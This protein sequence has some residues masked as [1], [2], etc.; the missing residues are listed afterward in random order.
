MVAAM[1]T[2]ST[3]NLIFAVWGAGDLRG[4]TL[5]EA[6]AEVGVETL[7]VNVQD[8]AVEGALALQHVETPIESVLVTSG[9]DPSGVLAI[10]NAYA[11]HVVGWEV[12]ARVVLPPPRV[13]NGNRAPV[14]AQ[15][16]FLRCPDSMPYDEWLAYW[17]G[18][19]TPVAVETQGTVGYVQNR[20]I[21]ALT[22]DTPQVDAIVEELFPMAALTDMHAYYGSSGDDDEL[23]RRIARLM[24]SV[25]HMGA[26]RDLD[27]VPTS[28]YVWEL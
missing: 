16:A 1:T 26:D 14:M 12:D 13:G 17:Q 2:L 3:T 5:R 21:K 18:P 4:Q 27:L 8:A 7:Q 24:E 19:H 28:R 20:V 22:P 15:L 6:L 25:A 9:G 23:Q 11:H 10:L